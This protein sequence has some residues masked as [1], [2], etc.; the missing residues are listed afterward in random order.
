LERHGHTCIN[1]TPPNNVMT[2]NQSLAYRTAHANASGSILH[3][4]F[5]VNAYS[6]ASAHGCEIEV[7]STN[8]AKYGQ[9][10]LTEIVKLGFESR[11]IKEPNLYMTKQ[12]NAVSILIEP[13]FCTSLSDVKLYNR[14]TLGLAIAKGIINVIGGTVI[15]SPVVATKPVV[16]IN[17]TILKLQQ[18]CNKLGVKGADDKVLVEDNINGANTIAAKSKLKV[19]MSTILV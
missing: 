15:V 11:G 6:D 3:I 5:H 10:V 17:T 13:F 16:V 8:G 2:V 14:T 19:Y 9:S 12:P 4:C 1:C 7:A 18:T